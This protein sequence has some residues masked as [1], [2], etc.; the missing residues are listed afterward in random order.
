MSEIAQRATKENQSGS[1][2]TV[3]WPADSVRDAMMA[4][5]AEDGPLATKIRKALHLVP[6]D[7]VAK[8]M[9][10]WLNQI[11]G[12]CNDNSLEVTPQWV[13]NSGTNAASGVITRPVLSFCVIDHI[14]PGFRDPYLSRCAVD[15]LAS[16]FDLGRRLL[17]DFLPADLIHA[18]RVQ[19]ACELYHCT[20]HMRS[21]PDCQP[22]WWNDDGP[23]LSRNQAVVVRIRRPEEQDKMQKPHSVYRPGDDPAADS[24][25]YE[26]S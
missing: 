4:F 11:C 25:L 5:V 8:N 21:V 3:G 17:G 2:D 12:Q 22:E 14:W 26:G 10:L 9:L 23:T 16:H 19:V 7:D 1:C 13:I 20:V 6:E 15:S 24:A 18:A